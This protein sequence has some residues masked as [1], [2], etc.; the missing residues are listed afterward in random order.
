MSWSQWLRQS[1]PCRLFMISVITILLY[2]ICCRSCAKNEQ[3]AITN[4]VSAD[5]V[6]VSPAVDQPRPGRK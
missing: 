2:V 3:T 6:V 4:E 1:F 5:M